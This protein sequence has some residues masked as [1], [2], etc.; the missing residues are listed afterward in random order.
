M[1]LVTIGLALGLVV[2]LAATRLVKGFLYGVTATDPIS[3]TGAALLLMAVA[4]LANYLP[5][6]QAS[7]ADPLIALR[8]D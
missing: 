6:R 7:R 4:L 8:R 5:A 1:T 3:F 2:A